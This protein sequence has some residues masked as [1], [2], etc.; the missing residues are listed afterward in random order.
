MSTTSGN[1]RAP[2]YG[3]FA[4]A[5]GFTGDP[6]G[7]EGL[8]VVRAVPRQLRFTTGGLH[9]SQRQAKISSTSDNVP[10]HHN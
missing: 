5:H 6:V 7:H 3:V 10:G 2:G 9:L 8:L 1:S 4:A